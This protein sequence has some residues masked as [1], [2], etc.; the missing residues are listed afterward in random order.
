MPGEVDIADTQIN[1][2]MLAREKER[3]AIYFNSL[4][5]EQATAEKNLLARSMGYTV[6]S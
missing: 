1:K 2:E 5:S 3:K 6:N 4:N